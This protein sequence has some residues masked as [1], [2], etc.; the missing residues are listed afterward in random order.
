MHA[1]G[2]RTTVSWEDRLDGWVDEGLTRAATFGDL[3]R[4]LPGV[5]P[6]EALRSLA[7]LRDDRADALAA[8]AR[9]DRAPRLIDQ[10][11]ALP[12]PHPLDSEFRFD[13]PT[14]RRLADVL[15]EVTAPGDE[16]LLVGTPTVAIEFARMRADRLVRFLGPRDGVTAAVAAAFGGKGLALGGGAGGTAAAA[17]VDP[18]WYARPFGDMLS[19]C[20]RGCRAG[21][22]AWVVLPPL[23]AR[24]GAAEDRAAFVAMARRAGL[25]GTGGSEL[26]WYRTPLFE[27]AAMELQGLGRLADWRRGDLMSFVVE[28]PQEPSSPVHLPTVCELTLRGV[29]LRI[30]GNGSSAAPGP[31]L[32]TAVGRAEVFS[33]VS[34][35]APGRERANLWTTGNRAFH[36]DAAAARAA[37]AAIAREETKV[38]HSGIAARQSDIPLDSGIAPPNRLIHQLLELIGRELDDARRLVGD[39]AWLDTGTEWTC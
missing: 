19:A 11:G 31:A 28:R 8:D 17:L 33:S 37:M 34:S 3:V 38:L 16:I 29:R 2:A 4:A 10:C 12:L 26:V 1:R 13:V 25:A 22:P 6:D 24:P 39:G 27:L 20:S 35:R 7:R 23:G 14:A 5:T 36:V 18:P 9:V 30:V 32:L 21:A 15:L